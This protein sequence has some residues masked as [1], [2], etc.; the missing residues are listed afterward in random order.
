MKKLLL[1][2]L[3]VNGSAFADDYFLEAAV[4]LHGVDWLQT[5]SIVRHHNY[6][7][8][9]P[10]LGKDP[11]LMAVN[12][13]MASTLA[14]MLVIHELLPKQ[15]QRFF[16]GTWALNNFSYVAGNY[17]IGVKIEL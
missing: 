16:R 9:N 15:P 3:L 7:E 17:S 13:Y 14:I 8:R 11:S 5:R 1:V 2:L 10:I 6:T 12:A 4:L